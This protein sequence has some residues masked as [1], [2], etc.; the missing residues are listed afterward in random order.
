MAE[1]NAHIGELIDGKYRIDRRLGYG[2][3]GAVYRA[4]HLGT[5]RTVAVKVI[6]PQYS[7][8]EE[9]IERFRVVPPVF[10]E[11]PMPWMSYL[12]STDDDLRSIYRY[13]NSLP[14]VKNETGVSVQPKPKKK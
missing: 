9:F 14:P 6:H 8:Q 4:T 11:S 10:R 12:R 1:Q 2:G 5:K 3:M 13:L 7:N